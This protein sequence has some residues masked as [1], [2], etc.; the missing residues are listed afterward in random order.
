MSTKSQVMMSGN[1][2]VEWESG[3]LGIYCAG[4]AGWILADGNEPDGVADMPEAQFL[5]AT[6]LP[7]AGSE[8]HAVLT[9]VAKFGHPRQLFPK[10]GECN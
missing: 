6:G 5:A 10:E 2:V 3:E 1:A 9:E 8:E 7:E 4:D